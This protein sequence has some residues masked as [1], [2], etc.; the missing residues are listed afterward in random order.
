MDDNKKFYGI[1]ESTWGHKWGYK[2]SGFVVNKDRS[3]TFTGKRYPICGK[4]L[5]SF[6]PFVE[7]ILGVEFEPSPKI[8]E[9]E[10]KYVSNRNINKLFMEDIKK[11]FNPDRFTHEDRERVLHSH[12]Q[13]STDEVYKV[14]YNK[15]DK[16]ADLV[17]YI[18]AEEETELLISLA[19]NCSDLQINQY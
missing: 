14:L 10:K 1:N 2:D 12:G 7:E 4:T 15:L 11:S 13:H 17:F 19:K 16:F 8:K 6:I 18:E 3:V 5:P 9:I